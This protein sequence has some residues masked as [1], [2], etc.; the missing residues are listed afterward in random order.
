M[1]FTCLIIFACLFITAC[2]EKPQL[3]LLGP[4][5]VIL[6]FGNS[7]THGTG[8]KLDESYPAVLEK[9]VGLTVIN[10]GIPAY[11]EALKVAET[12]YVLFMYDDVNHAF[13]NHT[14]AARY[15]EEAATLAWKRTIA[16]FNTHLQ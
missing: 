14:N 4:D 6:A 2:T 7:L 11:E 1:K 8:A 3:P 12:N 16:F 5:A 15:N 9:L 10:A 13:H